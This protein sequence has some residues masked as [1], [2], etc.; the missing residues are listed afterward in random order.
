[1]FSATWQSNYWATNTISINNTGSWLYTV[2]FDLRVRSDTKKINS[3][4]YMEPMVNS[5]IMYRECTA[6]SVVT[7]SF[8]VPV[9]DADNDIVR[10]RC[11]NDK[12]LSMVTVNQNACLFSVTLNTTSTGYIAIELQI[13]DFATANS[14]TALSSVPVKFFIVVTACRKHLFFH[15][16]IISE[17]LFFS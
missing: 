6:N 13:E 14:T 12:C 17:I 5:I 2:T 11:T 9:H 8:I 16:F 1:M 10:C 7:Q 4:P 3:A 15:R